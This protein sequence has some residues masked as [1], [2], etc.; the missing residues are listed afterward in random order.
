MNQPQRVKQ[1]SCKLVC[2]ENSNLREDQKKALR[3]VLMFITYAHRTL[4]I[5][6]NK[7]LNEVLGEAISKLVE[8]NKA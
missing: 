3:E 4:E 6:G 8:L 2:M 1:A 5:E 7:N